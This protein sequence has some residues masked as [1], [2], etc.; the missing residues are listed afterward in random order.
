[1]VEI[2]NSAVEEPIETFDKFAALVKKYQ[3]TFEGV[4]FLGFARV[5][6]DNAKKSVQN[7]L[8]GTSHYITGNV[9]LRKTWNTT[10]Y[11]SAYKKNLHKIDDPDVAAELKDLESGET[12][13]KRS[14]RALPKGNVWQY[15]VEWHSGRWAPDIYS[16]KA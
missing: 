13:L 12:W 15:V 3:G 14:A 5:L 8:Y 2:D 16:A 11:D 7:P 4:K 1:V 10:Q 6:P 9:V